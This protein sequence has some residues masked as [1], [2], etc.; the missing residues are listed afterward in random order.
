MYVSEI[1]MA[2][3]FTPKVI[4]I[5]FIIVVSI[6]TITIVIIITAIISSPNIT[7]FTQHYN[8]Q[9]CRQKAI[10]GFSIFV[11]CVEE[12]DQIFSSFDIYKY[13]HNFYSNFSHTNQN[14]L[15]WLLFFCLSLSFLRSYFI[16]FI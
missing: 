16:F 10:L 8:F 6:Q 3:K 9:L 11:C 4:H 12:V 14:V 7:S 13:S 2:I 15:N 5:R 1:I